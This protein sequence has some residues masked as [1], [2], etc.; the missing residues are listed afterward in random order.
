FARRVWPPVSI[1]LFVL[2]A[3]WILN[4]SLFD[5]VYVSLRQVPQL[6]KYYLGGMLALLAIALLSLLFSVPLALIWGAGYPFS[7]HLAR[8]PLR[9]LEILL[10]GHVRSRL[11][12]AN[13]LTG[14]ALGWIIPVSAMLIAQSR[15]FSDSDLR[16]T[17]AL[18]DMMT[19]RLPLLTG[20]AEPF[21][22]S[23]YIFFFLYVLVIP[24]AASVLGRPMLIRMLG[25][26]VGA[27][28]LSGGN[29]FQSSLPAAWLTAAILM[30][31]LDQLTHRVGLLAA[32]IALLAG[33]FAIRISALVAQTAA[34]LH[35]TGLWGWLL[36]SGALLFAVWR[37]L[38]GAELSTSEAEAAWTTE[39]QRANRVDRERLKAEFDVARR[40]Q[41]QMLPEHPPV[42]PG[43]RLAAICRP[44]REVG[45][46]LYDFIILPDDRLGIVVADVSGKGVP[47]SLYMTLTKG[48]LASVAEASSDPGEILREVNRHLY[49][50]CG[51]KMFVT[52]LLGVIDPSSQTFSYARAGHNPPV[53]RQREAGRTSLLRARGLGLGLNSGEVFNRA[54]TVETIQLAPR[55]KLFLYSDGITEAMNE[56]RDEYG[57]ERL[58]EVAARVDDLDAEQTRDAVLKDVSAFLGATP[59]QDDQT[60]VI[61]E[62]C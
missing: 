46:D 61:V 18:A 39:A 62:V 21:S 56:Q 4:S 32:I 1:G 28:A 3:F 45:G 40:A 17:D 59:P 54:L 36:L 19:A 29:L 38:R 50:A 44:A 27:T 10:R 2:I 15:L 33:D 6:Q 52:L 7:A 23:A 14:L 57:E 8:N 12:G 55:D 20:P 5:D 47:A 58:M 31:A 24:L 13:L 22:I 42:F 35:S 49:I 48:L 51:K 41:Q 37:A 9:S 16:S 11:V 53:W 30:V 34:P 25:V 26:I 60:L 43:Y